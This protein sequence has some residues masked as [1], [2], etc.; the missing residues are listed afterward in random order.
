MHQDTVYQDTVYQDTVYQDTVYQDTVYQD[1]VYQDTV[2]QDTVYKDTVYQDTVY[3]DTMYQDA[4]HQDTVYQDTVYQDT[5]GLLQPPSIHP[6]DK[7]ALGT[8][9]YVRFLLNVSSRAGEMAR[10]LRA[11]S[12]L[13]EVLSSNPSNHRAHNHP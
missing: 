10:W 12:I 11:L 1:T 3:K 5:D 8:E 13:P 6:K 2:Y 4:M 9:N 7:C